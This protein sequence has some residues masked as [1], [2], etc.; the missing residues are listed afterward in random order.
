M[1]GRG[2]R[3][4]GGFWLTLFLLG[5]GWTGLRAAP[6]LP[7]P[8]DGYVVDRAGLLPPAATW[9]ATAAAISVCIVAA[10]AFPSII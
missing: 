7:P 5:I 9:A 4:V 10:K 3:R 2:C 6:V 8:P 1:I